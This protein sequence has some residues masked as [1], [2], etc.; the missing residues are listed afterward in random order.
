MPALS[1]GFHLICISYTLIVM[2]KSQLS[3][4]QKKALDE[5]LERRMKNTGETR[6]QAA[7]HITKFLLAY[8]QDA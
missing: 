2:P 7:E 8:T 1:A 6:E 3:D 4:N 5:M